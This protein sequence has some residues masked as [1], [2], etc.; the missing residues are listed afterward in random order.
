MDH[1]IKARPIPIEKSIIPNLANVGATRTTWPEASR[2][3]DPYGGISVN[4][5]IFQWVWVLAVL[6]AYLCYMYLFWQYY[7]CT[8]DRAGQ[9]GNKYRTLL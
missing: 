7:A 8:A 3:L 2:F 6:L 5:V 1:G 4:H 9:W